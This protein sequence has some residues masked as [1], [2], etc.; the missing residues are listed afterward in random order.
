MVHEVDQP[1]AG[2]GQERWDRD[3]RRCCLGVIDRACV[4]HHG[5]QN[6]HG[7][8]DHQR[9]CQRNCALVRPPINLAQEGQKQNRQSRYEEQGSRTGGPRRSADS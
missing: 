9:C 7:H 1:T 2:K 3:H 6:T 8:G 5:P 4:D